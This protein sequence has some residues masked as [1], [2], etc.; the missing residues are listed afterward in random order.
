MTLLLVAERIQEIVANVAYHL[1]QIQVLNPTEA[2][3][4]IVDNNHQN[5]SSI[6]TKN[7]H[8]RINP[9]FNLHAIVLA[10]EN[11]TTIAINASIS[12]ATILTISIRIRAIITQINI[13]IIATIPSITIM[14]ETIVIT[15]AT[16]IMLIQLSLITNTQLIHHIHHNLQMSQFHPLMLIQHHHLSHFLLNNRLVHY[17]MATLL[18]FLLSRPSESRRRTD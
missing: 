13:T 6:P 7:H 15:I 11:V 3:A 17:L 8:D 5:Q 12:I 10:V 9:T 2:T 1:H 4:L 16:F 14:I 18:N